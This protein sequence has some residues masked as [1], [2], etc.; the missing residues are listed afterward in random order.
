VDA[1][2]RSRSARAEPSRSIAATASPPAAH[3]AG[4]RGLHKNAKNP[5]SN[6]RALDSGAVVL[7]HG[8]VG[9]DSGTDLAALR[10]TC[11]R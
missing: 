3:S 6:R 4:P 5:A 7:G 2:L 10:A 9:R 8:G 1:R 11:R